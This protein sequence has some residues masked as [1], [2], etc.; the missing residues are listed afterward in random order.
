[1]S[2]IESSTGA[3]EIGDSL[4]GV[5]RSLGGFF[6]KM[7]GIAMCFIGGQENR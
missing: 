4:K 7:L 5:E 2:N 3:G 1:M 6:D